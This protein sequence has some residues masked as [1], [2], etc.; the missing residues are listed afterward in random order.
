MRKRKTQDLAQLDGCQHGYGF[1]CFVGRRA[2]FYC[3]LC[4]TIAWMYAGSPWPGEK[5]E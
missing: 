5:F 1:I 4:R 2:G 3:V